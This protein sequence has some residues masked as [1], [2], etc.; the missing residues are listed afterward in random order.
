MDTA[1]IGE[2][3]WNLSLATTAAALVTLNA[4]AAQACDVE[5]GERIDLY[6]NGAVVT[7]RMAQD[8]MADAPAVLWNDDATGEL[9]FRRH[10][11]PNDDQ[12]EPATSVATEPAAIPSQVTDDR[13]RLWRM[14]AMAFDPASEPHVV[15]VGEVTP[16]DTKLYYVHRIGEQGWS[17]AEEL[18]DLPDLIAG[19]AARYEPWVEADFDPSGRLHVAYHCYGG[20]PVEP[21][22]DH[23]AQTL[24]RDRGVWS[25]PHL[26]MSSGS[27]M[28]MAVGADGV[29]HLVTLRGGG[30][31]HQAFYK[32][33][34]DGVTW[35]PGQGTQITNEPPG[36]CLAG[37][38]SCWPSITTDR[39]G[40]P[41][42]AYGVDP[43]P[44]CVPPPAGPAEC[45]W[46]DAPN[47]PEPQWVPAGGSIKVVRDL[48]S[49]F[50]ANT[51]ELV[52]GD[53]ALHG[54][55][56]EI[57]IDPV[58]IPYVVGPN[59]HREVGFDPLAGSWHTASYESSA[60]ARWLFLDT[61]ATGSGGWVAYPT[62]AGNALGHTVSVKHFRRTGSCAEGPACT[63][64]QERACGWC[65]TQT[66]DADSRW[67]ACSAEGSC[68]PEATATCDGQ[69]TTCDYECAWDVPCGGVGGA[70]GA[71]GTG[72]SA[73]SG[74]GGGGG[75]PPTASPAED[76]RAP[77]CAC[78]LPT[79]HRT[80]WSTLAFGCVLWAMASRRRQR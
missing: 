42:V 26:A 15:F 3:L 72:G 63:P 61:I 66:C 5:V 36:D 39:D 60:G 1:R 8:R 68:L 7:V 67:G 16:G 38:V 30:N 24:V 57:S 11:G 4:P 25:G 17:P 23:H 58:G 76:S 50:N 56:P 75:D 2:V 71:A 43:D 64:G 34:P 40:H 20:G 73:P 70:S 44:C 69:P 55:L 19:G 59:F 41:Y 35:P 33:S 13:P 53:I 10:T 77:G 80:A 31:Q 6:T 52:L 47:P 54:S 49:G 32:S 45:T 51:P 12:W 14:F 65:G 37:P 74:A 29:V 48:G 28:D 79:H 46:P 62:P 21:P 22:C 9:L 27:G 18:A 78:S